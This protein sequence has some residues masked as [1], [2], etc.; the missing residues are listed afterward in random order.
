M[1]DVQKATHVAAYFL[2][3]RGG[4]MSY[5]KLMKLMYLAE[6][7]FLLQHGERLVGDDLV[8]MQYGPVLSST[9]DCFFGCDEYWNRWINN[10]GQHDLELNPRIKVNQ[11]DPLDTFDELSVAEQ[12]VLD[13]VYNRYGTMNRWD[14]VNMLHDPKYCPE[15]SDPKGSSIRISTGDLLL[16]NGKTQE[17]TEAI[18]KKLEEAEDLQTVTKELV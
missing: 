5:L 2:W 13:S 6:R 18:L 1:F 10:P 3:K 17:Q 7:Q 14:L 15:W 9:Y 16:K 11:K 12:N 8:S 4:R